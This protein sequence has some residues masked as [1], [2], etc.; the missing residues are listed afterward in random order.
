MYFTFPHNLDVRRTSGTELQ[1]SS[2]KLLHA[3]IAD[4]EKSRTM[5]LPDFPV[6]KISVK[7]FKI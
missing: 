6:E 7:S 5:I 3:F 1:K 4:C 2:L